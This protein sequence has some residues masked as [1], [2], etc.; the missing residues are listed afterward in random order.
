MKCSVCTHQN[1]L[2]VTDEVLFRHLDAREDR[3]VGIY[4][5]LKD[6]TCSFLAMDFDNRNW[7]E[8]AAAIMQVCKAHAIP[9]ALER[10]RSGNG[11]HIWIFFTE[12]IA[13]SW[14]R[15]FGTIILTLTMK[16]RYQLGLDSYDR[17][18]P[19]QDTLPKGGFGNLIA[20]PLQG[21]PRKMGNSMFLDDNFMP[22][23]DQWSFLAQ[24][25]KM[26]E[27]EVTRFIQRNAEEDQ[28]N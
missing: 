24:L 3:T 20:L 19:N 10:S 26:T 18:F 5:M 14:V 9:A 13:A 12:P 7:Q 6:E 15:K 28:L 23:I 21:G 22:Y 4:P 11:G 27:E 1:F 17:L 16:Q 25:T 2:P 8:D